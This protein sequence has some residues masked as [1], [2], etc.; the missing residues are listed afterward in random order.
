MKPKIFQNKT[1]SKIPKTPTQ[2]K[3][4]IMARQ[5]VAKETGRTSEKGQPWGLVTTIYKNE[6]KAGKTAKKSDVTNAKVSKS[7]RK[8]KLP[9]KTKKK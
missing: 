6:E 5:I 9:N 3:R 4:W 8:Y 2:K 1:T 7:V